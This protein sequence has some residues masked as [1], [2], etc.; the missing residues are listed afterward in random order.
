MKP[1]NIR[2]EHHSNKSS[3]PSDSVDYIRI[4]NV[5]AL[6]GSALIVFIAL[7]MQIY[8]HE[9][10]CSMCNVQRLAFLLFGSGILIAILYPNRCRNGYLFSGLSAVVGS[11]M[12]IMQV[13]IHI[14]PGASSVGSAIFGIHLYGW[15]YI[16]YIVAIIY[17]FIIQLFDN[18]S[19]IIIELEYNQPRNIFKK[20]PIIVKFVIIF[21]LLICLGSL[22]SAFME[23]GFQPFQEGG[24]QH[25][26]IEQVINHPDVTITKE[27]LMQ[28]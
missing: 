7:F 8:Y 3:I 14:I 22:I 5:I 26:W 1:N 11:L 25:Y 21:Y 16:F 6:F 15:S 12:A 9:L 4:L 23:N 19:Q 13:F 10:P 17:L 24:Q 27:M 2:D 18:S 20:L 28:K